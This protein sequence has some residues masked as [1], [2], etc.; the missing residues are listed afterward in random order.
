MENRKKWQYLGGL[1][2]LLS[3]IPMI[4]CQSNVL[5][6]P[7]KPPLFIKITS[8]PIYFVDN[9]VPRIIKFIPFSGVIVTVLIGA[10]IGASIGYLVD[11]RKQVD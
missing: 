8:F 1:W 3:Y 10:L 7:K 9:Y 4:Y 11:K 6:I 5:C 2:G